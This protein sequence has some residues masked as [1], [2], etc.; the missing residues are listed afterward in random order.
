MS[1][2][3]GHTGGTLPDATESQTRGHW[4]GV[5][6]TLDQI[7][8]YAAQINMSDL[9]G[10][11]DAAM[12]LYAGFFRWVTERPLYDGLTVI[13]T[14]DN[15][16]DVW[17]EGI[18]IG[19]KQIS[20]IDR[21]GNFN[22]GGDYASLSGFNLA[23]DNSSDYGAV[24]VGFDDYL[25]SN[26]YEIINRPVKVYCVIDDVFYQIWGGVVSETRYNEKV[27]EFI[28]KDI[29]EN[30]HKPIPRSEIVL[31]KF[32]DADPDSLGKQ[33]PIVFGDVL[34]TKLFNVSGKSDPVN[35]GVSDLTQTIINIT[36]ATE[37][38]ID[39]VTDG[40]YLIIKTPGFDFQADH[41]VDTG[42]YYITVFKGTSQGIRIIG[43]DATTDPGDPDATTKIFLGKKLTETVADFNTNNA[44]QLDGAVLAAG[45]WFFRIYQ[46][47]ATYLISDKA[48]NTIFKDDLNN[49]DFRR[50][51]KDRLRYDPIPELLDS[52]DNSE[53][54]PYEAPIVSIINNDVDIEGDFVRLIP[55]FPESI[56][57]KGMSHSPSD[58][59][60]THDLDQN[61]NTILRDKD[62]TTSVGFETPPLTPIRHVAIFYEINFPPDFVVEDL[63]ELYLCFDIDIDFSAAPGTPIFNWAVTSY[64][65][66]EQNYFSDSHTGSLAPAA[67]TDPLTFNGLPNE[68]YKQGDDG[69]ENSNFQD[70]I[71]GSFVSDNFKLQNIENFKEALVSGKMLLTISISTGTSIQLESADIKQI[72]F[73]GGQKLNVIKDDMFIKVKGE[74]VGGLLTNNV[75]RTIKH[76]LETY[77]EIP[78]G[79]IDYGNLESQ[80]TRNEWRVGRQLESKKL[81]SKYL[82]ELASQS[83]VGIFPDRYGKRHTKS[84]LDDTANIWT[85]ADDNGTILEGTIRSFVATPINEVYND[86]KIDYDWNPGLKQFNKSLF[87][88]N[89][90]ARTEVDPYAAVFPTEF[91]STGADIDYTVPGGL[92]N[93]VISTT[94]L[95]GYATL[96]VVPA[97]A[98]V[99]GK[100]S[101]KD[102]S[103]SAFSYAT[104]TAKV[105]SLV[106]FDLQTK[107][108]IAPDTYVAGT[109][110]NHGGVSKKWT[111]WVGGINSYNT[112]K[113]YWEICY[114]SWLKTQTVNKL[115]STLGKCFWF[116]D[117][118]AFDGTGSTDNTA[119]HKYLEAHISWTTR[120]KHRVA[121][122]IP[123]TP[124]NI[125]VDELDVVK[126]KDQKYTNGDFRLGY[127]EKVKVNPKSD[128]IDLE[129]ILQPAGFE[130]YP[131]DGN[132]IIETGD[133]P[134]IITESGSFPNTITET[135]L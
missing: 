109:L 88:T 118:G 42:V 32:P 72:G 34:R 85:H 97:W 95:G 35:I 79:D 76:I 62:R 96:V 55:I 49:V 133:A 56:K 45:V 113:N 44:Y 48:V 59:T 135:G 81:S 117:G 60:V 107:D 70:E 12:G 71:V 130:S 4:A 58:V 54:N 41:F 75:H 21:I 23:I 16:G 13:P 52:F 5:V 127:I 101:F 11:T 10:D 91:E 19:R 132:L 33:V 116:I 47:N 18:M 121:Y 99:G 102:D 82:K 22:K 25:V 64:D 68:Y 128:Q 66:F 83:F 38:D 63:D 61:E 105:G 74:E 110:T 78:G 100:I 9:S 131:L 94:G 2:A 106:Y 89:T 8:H 57:Y 80:G 27:F 123:V 46:F 112:A 14:G 6:A 65:Q 15:E 125:E 98:A 67:I 73:Y 26:G 3:V 40:P 84:F 53:S 28:C 114:N 7:T 120:Q 90:D 36:A 39:G 37:Y 20:P 69:G 124:Q 43:N 31:Q 103:S 111:T 92:T 93:V 129:V 115:P 104:I 134:D 108:E 122:S 86:F 126:F 24:V 87:V 51:N 50:W 119:A 77:D 30:A 1:N 29:F 17:G